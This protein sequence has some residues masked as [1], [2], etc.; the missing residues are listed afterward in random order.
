MKT[1]KMTYLRE[2]F[3]MWAGANVYLA[4]PVNCANRTWTSASQ[5]LVWMEPRVLI[6]LP[7]TAASAHLPTRGFNAS[8][9]CVKLHLRDGRTDGQTPGIEFGAF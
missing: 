3:L 2:M 9:V 6:Y 7:I 8:C 4:S 1:S 5:V